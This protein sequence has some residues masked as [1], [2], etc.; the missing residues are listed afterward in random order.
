MEGSRAAGGATNEEADGESRVRSRTATLHRPH[1][2]PTSPTAAGR[3][4]TRHRAAMM[5]AETAGQQRDGPARQ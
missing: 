1:R 2:S 3:G 5:A 4:R